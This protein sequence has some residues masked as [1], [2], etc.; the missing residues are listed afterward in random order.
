MEKWEKAFRNA[1]ASLAVEGLHIK[2]EEETLIKEFLQNK[3][4]DEEF[5]KKALTMIK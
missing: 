2:S 1:K 5:Y 3:I 4:N